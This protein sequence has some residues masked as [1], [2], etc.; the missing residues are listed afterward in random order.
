MQRWTSNAGMVEPLALEL[1][2]LVWSEG[3]Q[4]LN[5]SYT[6]KAIKWPLSI[7]YVTLGAK[8]LKYSQSWFHQQKPHFKDTR[9][10][11]NMLTFLQ[12]TAVSAYFSFWRISD[13]VV[14]VFLQCLV[15]QIEAV[16]VPHPL[17]QPLDLEDQ[18]QQ[19]QCPIF[20]KPHHCQPHHCQPHQLTLSLPKYQLNNL[21]TTTH[22]KQWKSFVQICSSL[23][24]NIMIW[25]QI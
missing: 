23:A 4:N 21:P 22:N 11:W 7:L 17:D 13:S 18:I 9:K 10:L 16:V 15:H 2:W 1:E 24:G 25:L 5:E 3:D 19:F 6:W 20:L 12:V 8:G 14:I